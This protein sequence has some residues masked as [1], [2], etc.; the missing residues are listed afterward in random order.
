MW[1]WGTL[2]IKCADGHDTCEIVNWYVP[3]SILV[4][5]IN[6][7]IQKIFKDYSLEY[8]ICIV[9]DMGYI[10]NGTENLQTEVEIPFAAIECFKHDSV[11]LTH[12]VK[13]YAVNMNEK[14]GSGTCSYA[15]IEK[16]TENDGM[17]M[18]T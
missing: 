6:K 11:A 7:N 2:K 14:C 16:C 3:R 10:V 12:R 9:G 4:S 18:F 1:V 17:V 5:M 13:A 15:K 8:N